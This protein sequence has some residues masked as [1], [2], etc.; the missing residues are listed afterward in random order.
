[1]KKRHVIIGLIVIVLVIIIIVAAFNFNS[2]YYSGEGKKY[3]LKDDYPALKKDIYLENRI[4][5]YLHEDRLEEI[6]S[7][8]L[9]IGYVNQEEVRICTTNNQPAKLIL[10]NSRY[11]KENNVNYIV[12]IIECE[13]VYWVSE[14]INQGLLKESLY[15]PFLK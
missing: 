12:F 10:A 11:S 14:S 5:E 9:K 4:V 13:D 3:I 8:K 15:G 2:I 1:M 6:T 7:G